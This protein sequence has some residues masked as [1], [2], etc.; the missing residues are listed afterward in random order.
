[1]MMLMLMYMYLCPYLSS[2][3]VKFRRTGESTHTDNEG[4]A[5]DQMVQVEGGQLDMGSVALADG[6]PVPREFANPTDGNTIKLFTGLFAGCEETAL[7]ET[8]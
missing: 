7:T 8:R 6:A 2:S 3:V 5:R 4:G 1:M